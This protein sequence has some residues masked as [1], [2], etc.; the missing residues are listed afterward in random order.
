MLS[1][2]IELTTELGSFR[3]AKYKG[4]EFPEFHDRAI[5][6]ITY[7]DPLYQKYQK[8]EK[9][10]RDSCCIKMIEG[11]YGLL[12]VASLG[13]LIGGGIW[14]SNTS[15]E[16]DKRLYQ[17]G[18][19]SLFPVALA[20]GFLYCMCQKIALEQ[21]NRQK[22]AIIAKADEKLT[23]LANQA[24]NQIRLRRN[25]SSV[26]VS[27]NTTF[28]TSGGQVAVTI[29]GVGGGSLKIEGDAQQALEIAK[30]FQ[31]LVSAGDSSL[32]PPAYS[33]PSADLQSVP[34]SSSAPF[35]S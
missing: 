29:G 30:I 1:D 7:S 14:G 17:I 25:P 13:G 31:P 18:L 22:K 3:V 2:L 24:I 11:M 10:E 19:M 35:V 12:L 16:K 27:N 32:S 26:T 33:D 20:I 8:I 4:N 34:S 9:S 21:R 28:N 15:W 23:K 6:S 5:A